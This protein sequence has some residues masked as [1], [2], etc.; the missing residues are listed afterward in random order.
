MWLGGR[1]AGMSGM[2]MAEGKGCWKEWRHG[3]G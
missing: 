3:C 1:D 2:D